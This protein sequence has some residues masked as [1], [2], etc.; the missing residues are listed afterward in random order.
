MLLIRKTETSSVLYL[1]MNTEEFKCAADQCK[2]EV[3]I[4][5]I[6]FQSV[7]LNRKI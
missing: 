4:H 1:E 5:C 3:E 6:Y 7:K 2:N